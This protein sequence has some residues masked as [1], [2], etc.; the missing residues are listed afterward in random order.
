MVGCVWWF[1]VRGAEGSLGGLGVGLF[2]GGWPVAVG[3]WCRCGERVGSRRLRVR[4]GLYAAA[5]KCSRRSA[6]VFSFGADVFSLGADVFSSGADVFSSGADVSSFRADVSSF[7]VDVSSLG[8]EVFTR[9]D[10]A[11]AW[12]D[13]ERAGNGV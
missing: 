4:R 3:A 9:P 5:R 11:L 12:G 7:G 2:Q 6:N 8:V 13:A 1:T 10:D